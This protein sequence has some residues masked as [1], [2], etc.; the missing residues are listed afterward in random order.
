MHM[1]AVLREL[2]RKYAQEIVVIGVHSAKFLAEKTSANL[3]P[4]IRRLRVH[5]PVVNE[6]HF[7]V[8]HSYAVSA[9]P[10]LVF[11]DPAGKIMGTY[12]GEAPVAILDQIVGQGACVWGG[13]RGGGGCAS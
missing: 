2:E 10:T 8:W 5:H 11:M 13:S 7:Q 6:K 1:L 12:Q 4:A 9:W 3:R